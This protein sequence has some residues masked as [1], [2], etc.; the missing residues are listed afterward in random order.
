MKLERKFLRF[1]TIFAN[2]SS[3]FGSQPFTNL[4]IFI[5]RETYSNVKVFDTDV[6]FIVSS[7][8][9]SRKNPDKFS[10]P[11]LGFFIKYPRVDTRSRWPWLSIT[12]VVE[13][14]SII[15]N[16]GT[17]AEN[18]KFDYFFISEVFSFF[19]TSKILCEVWRGC[20]LVKQEES[21]KL[22]LPRIKFG[23]FLFTK[24]GILKVDIKK[25]N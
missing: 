20:I 16:N 12:I 2:S 23:E 3:H 8:T 10:F 11:L 14:C 1:R 19:F 13:K 22:D 25:T 5:P 9:V 17:W 15:L 18:I 7:P 4:R 6:K 21:R 24:I